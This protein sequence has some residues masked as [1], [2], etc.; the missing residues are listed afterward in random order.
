[1]TFITIATAP[2]PFTNPHIS[3]IQRNALQSWLHLGPDVEVFLVGDEAGMAEVAAE[4]GV[5]HLPNVVRNDRGTPLVSSI[6][7]V[8]RQA[9]SSP[10]LAFANT[11]MLL[12]PDFIEAARKV[13]GQIENFLIVGTRWNLDVIELLDFSP[14]WDE[15][16]S[17]RTKTQGSMHPPVGSDYFIFPRQCYQNIPNF[18]VGRPMW[19]NWMM[20]HA[21][22]QRWPLIDVSM[23][24]MVIHQSHDYSHLP[25]NRPPYHMPEA[26]N[27]IKLAGGKRRYISVGDADYE[28][29]DGQVRPMHLTWARFW[30]SVE[31][32]PV[33][34]I[35]SY[36]LAEVFFAVFHPSKAWG[37]W[38]GRLV[39]KLRQLMGKNNA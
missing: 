29:V 15:R 30:R 14:G 11:D 26:L 24:V 34:K 33:V 21:R 8:T 35:D 27:N 20:Y 31:V 22:R 5:R 4:Y 7:N 17:A 3:T 6:F 2:K 12:M 10:L 9:S 28:L 19:D 36:F 13:Y 37:E 16:L 32:F 23:H 18:A 1:M 39:Y 38:R 25:G